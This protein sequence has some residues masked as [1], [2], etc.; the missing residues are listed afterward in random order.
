MRRADSLPTLLSLT[1]RVGPVSRMT[2]KLVEVAKERDLS[3]QD[4]THMVPWVI[5]VRGA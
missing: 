2:A 5:L 1:P 4:S 3:L